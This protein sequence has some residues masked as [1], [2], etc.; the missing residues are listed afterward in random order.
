MTRTAPDHEWELL[1]AMD[2]LLDDREAPRLE[3]AHR[4][5]LFLSIIA[6]GREPR[7]RTSYRRRLWAAVGASG[8]VLAGGI[9]AAVVLLSSTAPPAF[10]GWTAAPTT[11]TP[12]ALAAATADCNYRW[13]RNSP[14]D[15]TTGDAVLSETRGAYTAAIY[16]T[17]ST[18]Y[19]C[20]S[21]G[22]NGTTVGSGGAP[23]GQT[24]N[25]TV[26]APPPDQ[27]TKPFGGGGSAPGFPGGNPN[28]PLP[29]RWQQALRHMTNPTQRARQEQIWRNAL[30]QGVASY[31]YGRA[32]SDVSAVTLTI[33]G[34]LTVDATVQNGWYFAWWPTLDFPISVQVTTSSGTA[35][36]TLGP[37]G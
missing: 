26:P 12:A 8:T 34:G 18:V 2:P 11:A 28:G 21:N 33:T 30:S 16:V 29:Q 4:E 17:S 7:R 35:T 13:D 3:A 25:G 32:G 5:D 31:N 6:N 36:T 27:I 24:A 22:G 15:M 23:F 19:D 10:A 14:D 1:R 9:V 37:L 20:I